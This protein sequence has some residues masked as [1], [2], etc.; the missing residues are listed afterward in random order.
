MK[1][2]RLVENIRVQQ[3]VEKGAAPGNR[4]SRKKKNFSLRVICAA[5]YPHRVA[6][7]E[8]LQ[9]D[10][11]QRKVYHLMTPLDIC[12][13]E[14]EVAHGCEDDFREIARE[15]GFAASEVIV[16]E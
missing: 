14:F 2:Y 7:L 8:N 6:K 10:L 3:L 12:R 1:K 15:H 5:D 16:C 9:H 4:I 13:G 11:L